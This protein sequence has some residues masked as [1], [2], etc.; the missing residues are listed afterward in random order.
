MAAASN[1]QSQRVI[2]WDI[3]QPHQGKPLAKW[4]CMVEIIWKTVEF[5]AHFKLD[6]ESFAEQV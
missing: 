3:F 6:R 1:S 4:K 2:L 5:Y